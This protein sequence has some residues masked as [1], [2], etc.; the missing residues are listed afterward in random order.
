V[1]L[2]PEGDDPTRDPTLD[3]PTVDDPDLDDTDEYAI[4]N[5]PPSCTMT[6]R[7]DLAALL[8]GSVHPGECCAIENAGPIPVA[9]ARDLLSDS[10]L[11]F[12]FHEAGDIRAISH[13]GRH[14]NATVRTALAHRDHHRCVVPGCGVSYG[15]EIDHIQP[16]EEYGLTELDNLALLCHHH[17]HLKTYDGWILTKGPNGPDATPTWTFVPQ[18]PFGQEPDLGIDTPDGNADWWE[19]QRRHRSGEDAADG[20]TRGVTRTEG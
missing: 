10:F 4:I 8:R 15:L 20:G 18:P 1:G 3:D 2:D 6:V 11:K 9:V 7:V 12:V 16:L 14:I 5:R 13:R 19:T 17:H